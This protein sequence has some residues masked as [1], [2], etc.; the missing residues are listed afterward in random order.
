MTTLTMQAVGIRGYSDRLLVE[1][2]SDLLL[3]IEE[4]GA[5]IE[6]FEGLKPASETYIEMAKRHTI[7]GEQL[8]VSM[9]MVEACQFASALLYRVNKEHWAGYDWNLRVLATSKSGTL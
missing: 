8:P 2:I 5:G 6:E 3:F 1:C 4:G 7:N 9:E